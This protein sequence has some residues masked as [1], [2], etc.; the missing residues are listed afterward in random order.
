[1]SCKNGKTRWTRYRISHKYL[2]SLRL[3]VCVCHVQIFCDDN[4]GD[5]TL[6]EFVAGA[7]LITEE[8]LPRS[9]VLEGGKREM[10]GRDTVIIRCVWSIDQNR[11]SEVIESSCG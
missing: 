4:V 1:M 2:E 7:R 9:S 11:L 3:N 10:G 8:G 6:I 5:L